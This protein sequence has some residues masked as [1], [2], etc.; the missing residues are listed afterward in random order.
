MSTDTVQ[1]F[2]ESSTLSSRLAN[3]VEG[4]REHE[5]FNFIRFGLERN[6]EVLLCSPRENLQETQ[7]P[8]L[9]A[10]PSSRPRP[11][12]GHKSGGIL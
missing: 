1:T 2:V 11:K 12:K 4:N 7:V 3:S 9:V 5:L 6:I 10:S 8:T